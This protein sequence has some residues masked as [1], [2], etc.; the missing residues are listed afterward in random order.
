VVNQGKVDFDTLLHGGIGKPLSDAVAVRFRGDLLADLGQ[1]ILA[2]G[3]LD[4]GQ[5][6]GPFAPEIDPA[7]EQVP[8]GA[9]R[10]GIARGLGEHPTAE[11]DG[12]L[13][14]VD[15]VFCGLA[16]VDGLH[17][18]GVAEDKRAPFLGTQVCEPVSGEEPFNGDDN[19][20]PRG[21][22]DLEKRLWASSHIAVHHDLAVL[23]QDTDVHGSGMKVEAAISF[24]L[25]GAESGSATLPGTKKRRQL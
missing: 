1:V 13:V 2:V 4:M 19:V 21:R 17:V 25:L 3:V 22:H 23:V 11:Q 24:V 7:P 20:G 16:A 6:F 9:H 14:G 15:L 8:G 12:N 18:E 5:Q 10:G